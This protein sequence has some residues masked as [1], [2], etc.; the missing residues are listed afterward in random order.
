M[1]PLFLQER[2]RKEFLRYRCAYSN[3][4]L[5]KKQLILD[6][7]LFINLSNISFLFLFLSHFSVAIKL[8]SIS[9]TITVPDN[10]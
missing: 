9:T 10:L 7:I 8:S 6:K 2:E 5:Y 3:D 4:W 1:G